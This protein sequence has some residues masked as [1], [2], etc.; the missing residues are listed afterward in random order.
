MDLSKF[1]QFGLNKKLGQFL[2]YILF[3]LWAQRPSLVQ[4]LD[5]QNGKI[6][7]RVSLLPGFE[8]RGAFDFFLSLF[9]ISFQ[10]RSNRDLT[11]RKVEQLKGL[12]RSNVI[13]WLGMFFI[14][15]WTQLK[16]GDFLHEHDLKWAMQFWKMYF[17]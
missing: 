6:D 7:L 2:I 3:M 4:I 13:R 5:L 17:Y 1:W 8:E 16:F 11:L 12:L 10:S 14:C 15:I 9:C